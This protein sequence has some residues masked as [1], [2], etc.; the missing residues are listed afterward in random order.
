MTPRALLLAAVL[1]LPVA[2]QGQ[3]LAEMAGGPGPADDPRALAIRALAL[4]ALDSGPP[5]PRAGMA[6]HLR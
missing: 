6:Q 2:A 3:S 5:P 4:R 1:V